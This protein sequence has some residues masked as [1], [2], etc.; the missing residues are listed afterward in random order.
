[1]PKSDFKTSMFERQTDQSHLVAGTSGE[2]L[3]YLL[4]GTMSS[5][6]KERSSPKL[7]GL[8]QHFLWLVATIWISIT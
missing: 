8:W 2:D 7:C 5:H 3:V 6:K 1:M 4:L